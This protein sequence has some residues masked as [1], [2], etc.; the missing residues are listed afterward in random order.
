MGL[1]KFGHWSAVGGASWRC[2]LG[3]THLSADFNLLV[4]PG[5]W[6]AV[7][8]LSLSCGCLCTCSHIDRHRH[9]HTQCVDWHFVALASWNF[10]G[11]NRVAVAKVCRLQYGILRP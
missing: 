9:L 7:Q 8:N 10:L 5:S 1:G 3:V 2:S 4:P 6:L 11:E